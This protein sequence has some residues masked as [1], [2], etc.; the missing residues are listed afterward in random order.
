[1]TIS[2]AIRSRAGPGTP[3]APSSSRASSAEATSSSP[4]LREYAFLGVELNT[5]PWYQAASRT[6]SG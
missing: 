2:S 6:R 5:A 4:P 3:R 1:M